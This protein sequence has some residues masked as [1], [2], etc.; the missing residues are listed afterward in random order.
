MVVADMMTLHPLT[1]T[2]NTSVA[3]ALR[4]MMQHEYH[5]LP[6][7]SSQGHVVGIINQRDCRRALGMAD[8]AAPIPDNPAR[9]GDHMQPAPISVEPNTPVQEAARLI[10]THHIRALP[11]IRGETLV[12][13]I[14]VSDLLIAFMQTL[15]K[16]EGDHA[17]DD[18]TRERRPL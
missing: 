15:R 14:T 3:A 17:L 9:V 13:I 4:L 16:Y 1:T 6:V 5:Q 18:G 7:M 2:P 11:V 10:T 8:P 12:G